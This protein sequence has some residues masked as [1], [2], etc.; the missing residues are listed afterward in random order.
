MYEDKSTK[1]LSKCKIFMKILHFFG[2]FRV[3]RERA[4]RSVKY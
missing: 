2:E 4:K 1:I 3:L